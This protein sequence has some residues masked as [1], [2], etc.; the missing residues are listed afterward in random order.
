MAKPS[1]K[2]P[3]PT[4]CSL[5][6]RRHSGPAAAIA[7]KCRRATSSRCWRDIA[8]QRGEPVCPVQF[9]QPPSLDCPYSCRR[10]APY[11]QLP[12]VDRVSIGDAIRKV[13]DPH[14][15]PVRAGERDRVRTA[16]V[17]RSVS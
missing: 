10:L 13:R 7:R 9:R 8:G 6:G 17:C 2:P 11:R 4:P 14:R 15:L 12:D 1:L 3:V 16:T 5:P